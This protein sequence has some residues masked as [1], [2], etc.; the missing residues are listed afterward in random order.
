MLNFS[1]MSMDFAKLC[2][3]VFALHD[4]IRYA[5]IIDDTGTL[6]AGGLRK[7]LDSMTEQDNDELYLAQ[8]AIRKSM[9]QRFD[10]T[11]EKARL[12]RKS[13]RLN[14]SHLVSSYAVFC[15]KK[16]T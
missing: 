13:T 4:D 1:Y 5:G 7:G 8:T 15:L 12:D 9:R 2:E 3:G 10:N 11:M 6:I 16:K 14:S